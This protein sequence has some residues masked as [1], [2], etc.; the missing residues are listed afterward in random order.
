DQA[1]D[2]AGT[3]GE[4]YLR[5][6]GITGPIPGCVK[7]LDDARVGEHGVVGILTA[8]GRIV[9]TQLGFIDPAGRKTTVP[10][11]RRRFMLQK[12]PDAAFVLEYD[13]MNTVVCEGLEDMASI[14][15]LGHPARI[16]GLPG[17]GTL[18]HLPV[19]RG[20]QLVVVRDGDES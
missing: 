12:A 4:T 18:K 3:P 16:I 7:F 10:P 19:Q 14:A 1:V 13:G 9:G 11:Y 8:R 15:M 2:I 20:A 17:I 5:S 6:R